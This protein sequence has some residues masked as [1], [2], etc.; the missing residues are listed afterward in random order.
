M[1]GETSFFDV[2]IWCHP[3]EPTIS[4]W[5]FRVPVEYKQ[6]AH[7]RGNIETG[8]LPHHPHIDHRHLCLV[9]SVTFQMH[10]GTFLLFN[11]FPALGKSDECR[12][13]F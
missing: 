4:M 10:H 8:Q 5:M 6:A 1:F 11:G 13:L 12:V 3:S 7:I 2:R 9:L